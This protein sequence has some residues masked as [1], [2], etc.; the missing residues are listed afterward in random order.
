MI[1][2]GL[3]RRDLGLDLGF[4]KRH[5]ALTPVRYLAR[6]SHHVDIRLD[7]TFRH[8]QP[9]PLAGLCVI[10]FRQEGLE[11]LLEVCDQVC[12]GIRETIVDF[13]DTDPFREMG[14][15]SGGSGSSRS[16]P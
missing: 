13:P 4:G 8:L 7:I 1:K 10:G 6:L 15:A 16:T 9:Y 12:Y 3:V 14:K 5:S 11:L 2:H